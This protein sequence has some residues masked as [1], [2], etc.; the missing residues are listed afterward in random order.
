MAKTFHLSVNRDGV[1]SLWDTQH[2]AMAAKSETYVALQLT[3]KQAAAIDVAQKQ[4]SIPKPVYHDSRICFGINFF[5]S[6]SEANAYAEIVQKRGD[7]Y[8][9]GYFHGMACGREPERDMVMDG[10]KL[11]AVT[12]R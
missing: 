5:E 4:A 8:N 10:R 2:Q 9:G 1:V 7:T 3:P 12:V 6:E 11:F